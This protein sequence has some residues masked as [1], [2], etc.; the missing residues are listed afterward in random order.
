MTRMRCKQISLIYFLI[1][2]FMGNLTIYS[3]KGGETKS[4]EITDKTLHLIGVFESTSDGNVMHAT[5]GQTGVLVFGPYWALK[6][7]RYRVKFE[8]MVSGDPDQEV[9]HIDVNVMDKLASKAAADLIEQKVMSTGRGEWK[10]YTIDFTARK[11]EDSNLLYEFRVFATG[12][13]DVKV[14][15][16]FLTF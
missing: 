15:G 3:C 13:G 12:T 8:L 11:N 16:I 2:L 7:G 5:K 9:A 6:E 4:V 14:K 10:E 1:M